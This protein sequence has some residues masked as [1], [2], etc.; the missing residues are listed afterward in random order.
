MELLPL[1]VKWQNVNVMWISN[2]HNSMGSA[3]DLEGSATPV[4]VQGASR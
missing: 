1:H 4:A 3:M 2:A